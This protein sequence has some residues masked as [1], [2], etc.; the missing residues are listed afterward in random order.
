MQ[1]C[2]PGQHAIQQARIEVAEAKLV[3]CAQADVAGFEGG[4]GAVVDL[5]F[6]ED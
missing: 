6:E 2:K 5:Q 1:L 3:G 4:R